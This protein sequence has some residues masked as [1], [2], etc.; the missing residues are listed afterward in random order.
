MSPLWARGRGWLRASAEL[1]LP[2]VV[3]HRWSPAVARE[4]EG[5]TAVLVEVGLQSLEHTIGRVMKNLAVVAALSLMAARWKRSEEPKAQMGEGSNRE[6][7]DAFYSAE[8]VVE[9][10]V[11]WSSIGVFNDAGYGERKRE[12]RHL[13]KGNGRGGRA[14]SIPCG[15]GVRRPYGRWYR[16]KAVA[17]ASV[18]GGA[19]RDWRRRGAWLGW[20][21]AEVQEENWAGRGH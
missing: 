4:Q 10:R 2:G 6:A 8:E 17:P 15:G 16:P 21:E 3:A 9:G 7:R 12:R 14:A 20:L 5:A 19:T 13:M 11:G 18:S 1:T